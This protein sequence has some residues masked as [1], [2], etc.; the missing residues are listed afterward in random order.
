MNPWI[1]FNR[2]LRRVSEKNIDL[3]ELVCLGLLMFA[4]AEI[5]IVFYEK[6]QSN[7]QL[8]LVWFGLIALFLAASTRYF[9][10]NY[11]G[12]VLR[13]RI[14]WQ[15]TWAASVIF[16]TFVGAMVSGLTDTRWI[17]NICSALA[18]AGM[19]ICSTS[20]LKKGGC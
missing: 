10:L 6:T 4:A 16:G 11:S 5:G 3:V 12:K 17:G 7:L 19:I 18:T 2:V 15:W 9:Y 14:T 13:M 1:R 8:Y 20:Y